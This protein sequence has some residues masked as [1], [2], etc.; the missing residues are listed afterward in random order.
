[1]ALLLQSAQL[2]LLLLLLLLL[3]PA[4]LLL[5]WQRPTASA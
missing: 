1:V 2:L 3:R 4:H 5:A